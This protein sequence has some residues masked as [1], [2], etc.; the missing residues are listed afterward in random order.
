MTEL[1]PGISD[2]QTLDNNIS[3]LIGEEEEETYLQIIFTDGNPLVCGS[4]EVNGDSFTNDLVSDCGRKI[5]GLLELCLH[6]R[7]AVDKFT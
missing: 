4:W 6:I 1:A 5:A 7:A 3:A 2:T